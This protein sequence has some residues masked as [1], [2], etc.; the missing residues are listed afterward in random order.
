[1]N[2]PTSGN[3]LS[4]RL[5]IVLA[6]S[7]LFVSSMAQA[8]QRL[9]MTSHV[10]QEVVNGQAPLVGHLPGTQHLSLAISLPLRNES[11]L[12][13]LVQQIYDPQSPKYRQYLSVQEFAERFAPAPDDYES[14]VRFAKSNG[15]NVV[16]TYANRMVVDVEGPVASIE[17]AFHVVMNL[18]QHP[19][20]NRAFYSPDREPSL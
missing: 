2:R 7:L 6:A 8:E 5:P 10:H 12:R 1:M 14:V 13:D 18:Y 11:G 9:T 15:L 17:S 16:D 20:E 3:Q 19:T 4:L